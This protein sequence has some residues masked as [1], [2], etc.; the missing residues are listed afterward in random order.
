MYKLAVFPNDPLYLYFQKG[1]VKDRYWNPQNLFNEVH[2]ISL[3]ERDI[4]PEKMQRVAG[5][6][7]LFIHS[8]GRP[9]IVTLPLYFNR[10]FRIMNEVKPDLVKAHHPWHAGSL[11]VYCAR[12]LGI[13]SVISIHNPIDE[14]R[15]RER[16]LVLYLAKLLEYYCFPRVD[17]V[18]AMT[19]YL[20]RYSVR[21]GA[22]RNVVIFNRVYLEQ[23]RPKSN[24]RLNGV[25][26]ILSVGRL[27]GQKY[28]E[29]LIR[30]V[31]DLN[32]TLTLIGQ[33][34]MKRY[35]KDLVKERGI[36]NK[37]TFIDS[38][39]NKDIDRYYQNTDIFAIATHY[40]GFCIPILEAMASC[41]PIVASNIP[42]ISEILGGTGFLVDNEA[43]SFREKLIKLIES[44][45]LRSELGRRARARA[46]TIDGD[47]M[48]GLEA[49]LYRELLAK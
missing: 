1:E 8:I 21:M 22:R 15:I 39:V 45:D 2:I 7:K 20:K 24:H 16:R 38:V 25:P 31:V 27:D 48:E 44:E 17:V 28:Q 42:S 46:E 10:A 33:G 29:C 37:V 40:E 23:F 36:K 18:V 6:A 43:A 9:S 30:A 49:D 3:C 32:V 19:E 14:Q 41:L 47:K 35:L 26:K 13:P 12:K 5:Q 34:E 4:E 11:G